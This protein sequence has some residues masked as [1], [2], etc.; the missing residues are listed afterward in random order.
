MISGSRY[1]K[2]F[3]SQELLQEWLDL[4]NHHSKETTLGNIV[5]IK[6][7]QI[8]TM[9]MRESIQSG[10]FKDQKGRCFYGG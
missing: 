5:R 4:L 1:Y 9:G 10:S 8:I 2:T 6:L 3:S 7:S